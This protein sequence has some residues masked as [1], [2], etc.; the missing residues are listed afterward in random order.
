MDQEV[1][2]FLEHYGI[3]GMRWG[4]RKSY[5][6]GVSSKVNR[7]ARKDAEEFARAKAFYGKGAGTRRKLIN[8]VV[9]GKTKRIPG[10][11]QA[12]DKHLSDQ[13]SSRHATKAVSE[14]K[15]TD[16]KEKN[17]QRAGAIARR[18]TGEFGTQAAFVALVAGG[19]A[20]SR[21]AKGQAMMR[22]GMNKVM[23]VSNEFKRRQGAKKLN[24]L[25]KN[26]T[27]T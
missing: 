9:E 27:P 5:P 6:G 26:M 24:D 21:S 1:E 7:Q 15:R 25:L 20:F 2:E 3:K 23:N 22:S 4:Q 10:Y 8:Q 12:F 19:A 11:K 18:I 17:K 16:R 14:R 13:D